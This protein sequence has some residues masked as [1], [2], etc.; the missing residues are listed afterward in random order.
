MKYTL[1][2]GAL[3]EGADMLES[4]ELPVLDHLGAVALCRQAL[5]E[6]VTY[7]RGLA[8]VGPKGSGKTLGIT[9][10]RRW[11]AGVQRERRA[12]DNSLRVMKVARFPGLRI[13]TEREVARLLARALS[14]RTPTARVAS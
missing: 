6:C 14:L 13:K 9:S 12:A 8:L 11:V 7:R 2:L 4:F 3:S 10:A 5:D 1:D